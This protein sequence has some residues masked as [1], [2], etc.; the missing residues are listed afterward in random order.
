VVTI[1]GGPNYPT[2]PHE[3]NRFLRAY[4]QIDFYVAKEGEIAF[5]KLIEELLACYVAR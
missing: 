2:T 3:Q 1:F 5:T 4:P